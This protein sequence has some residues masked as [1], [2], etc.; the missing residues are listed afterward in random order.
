MGDGDSIAAQLEKL[1]AL[2]ASGSL[3]EA[4]FQKLKSALVAQAGPKVSGTATWLIGAL[5]ALAVVVALVLFAMPRHSAGTSTQ[6]AAQPVAVTPQAPKPDAANSPIDSAANNAASAPPAGEAPPAAA[7]P[8][9]FPTSFDCTQARRLALRMICANPNLAAQ[10]M[11]LAALYRRARTNAVDPSQLSDQ[12]Q[13]W[14][15][16][17]DSCTSMG[18]LSAVYAARRRELAQW[19][20]N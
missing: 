13:E 17:R 10:D 20:T 14:L 4:E 9:T 12:Q 3:N 11:Q 8:P 15:A 16:A 6:T 7:P 19:I 5:A 18:C 1:Q 2:R